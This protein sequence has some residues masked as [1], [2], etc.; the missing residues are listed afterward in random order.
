MNYYAEDIW[1]L[2]L[3]QGQRLVI[4]K[5]LGWLLSLCMQPSHAQL[6]AYGFNMALSIISTAFPFNP[7]EREGLK[8]KTT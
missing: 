8:Y 6:L 5:L 7:N 1:A 3:S 4:G 2:L